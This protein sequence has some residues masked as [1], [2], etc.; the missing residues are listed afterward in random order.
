MA[1]ASV[2]LGQISDRVGRKR[3]LLVLAVVSGVGSIVKWFTRSTFWGFCIS[4]FVFGF[5][6]GNVRTNNNDCV[7][8]MII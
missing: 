7:S 2:F 3:V 1:I 4:S 8:I 5:F 6:L